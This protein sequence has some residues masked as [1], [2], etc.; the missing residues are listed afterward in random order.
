M[1]MDDFPDVTSDNEPDIPCYESPIPYDD[2]E[3]F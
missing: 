2:D 1:K 3:G